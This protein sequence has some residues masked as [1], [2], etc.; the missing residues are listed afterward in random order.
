MRR[1]AAAL[2]LALALCLPGCTSR[3]EQV[4]LPTDD[5]VTGNGGCVLLFQ[6]VDVIANPT[7]GTPMVKSTTAPLVWP[8]GFSAWRVGSEVEVLDAEGQS[9]LTT[10]ARYWMCPSRYIY[11]WV[12][13]QV[14]PCPDCKLESGVM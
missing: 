6:V 9:V 8:K 12:I 1:V 14:K 3:G 4:S 10:G 2:A 11:Q 13:G 7:T 5:T